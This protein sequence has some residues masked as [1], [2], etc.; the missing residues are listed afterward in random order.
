MK[1]FLKAL[2]DEPAGYRA[3]GRV[4]GLGLALAQREQVSAEGVEHFVGNWSAD[5]KVDVS[6]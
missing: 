6:R 2:L 3:D 4:F 1:A 5:R